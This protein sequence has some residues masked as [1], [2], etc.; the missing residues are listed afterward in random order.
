MNIIKLHEFSVRSI[1]LR[2][3]DIEELELILKNN[4]HVEQDARIAEGLKLVAIP[5]NGYVVIVAYTMSDSHAFLVDLQLAD[6]KLADYQL[7][8]IEEIARHLL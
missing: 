7:T 8:C 6:T 2:D 4:I 5:C 3:D 1:A